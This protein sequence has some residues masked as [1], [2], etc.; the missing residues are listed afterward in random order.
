MSDFRLLGERFRGG[1]DLALR[2][3]YF[4]WNVRFWGWMG[5][6]LR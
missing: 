2:R 4:F 1:I 3:F 6:V 5:G